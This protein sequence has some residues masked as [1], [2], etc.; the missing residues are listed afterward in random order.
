MWPSNPFMFRVLIME[1]TVWGCCFHHSDNHGSLQDICKSNCLRNMVCAPGLNSVLTWEWS[2]GFPGT[3]PLPHA[4]FFVTDF[5]PSHWAETSREYFCEG[6]ETQV[7]C[8]LDDWATVSTFFSSRVHMLGFWVSS[9][10]QSSFAGD[11]RLNIRSPCLWMEGVWSVRLKDWLR[12]SEGPFFS[13]GNTPMAKT[14]FS[15]AFSID[16]ASGSQSS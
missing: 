8:Y 11:N 4:E 9:T 10:S 15:W 6:W 3:V 13:T 1:V 7:K 5:I 14:L 16:L 12:G 2:K